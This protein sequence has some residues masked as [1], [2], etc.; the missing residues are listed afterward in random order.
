MMAVVVAGALIGA[1]SVASAAPMPASSVSATRVAP[2]A[3]PAIKKFANCT[4]LNKV[5]KGG[6]A[7]AGVKY[8]KVN[9]KNK[10]FKV[11]PTIS[12][13]LYKANSKMDRDKD[14]IAC[15]KG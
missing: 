3:K 6:V 13:A 14:G 1:P 9:G 15:E 7:K 2:A 5:H 8:N 10:A 4:A 11:K 12:S